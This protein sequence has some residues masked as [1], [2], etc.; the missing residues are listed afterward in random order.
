VPN[1]A[2]IYG[3]HLML[4]LAE[5]EMQEL[6]AASPR[7]RAILKPVCRMLGIDPRVLV[8]RMQ[9]AAATLP[10]AESSN[11]PNAQPVPQPDPPLSGPPT[12]RLIVPR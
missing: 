6:I 11:S 7:A 2:S 3:N 4:V 5:P 8:G 1:K 10:H 12:G 9:S